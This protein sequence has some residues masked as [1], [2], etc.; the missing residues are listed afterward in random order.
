MPA[1]WRSKVSKRSIRKHQRQPLNAQ[2]SYEC[3]AT[4]YCQDEDVQRETAQTLEGKDHR[5]ARLV[6]HHLEK[7]FNLGGGRTHKAVAGFSVRLC[8]GQIFCLLGHNGAGKST[9]INCITGV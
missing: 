2:E 3:M 1:Y 6:I 9:T 4:Q 5:G 7:T 8:R